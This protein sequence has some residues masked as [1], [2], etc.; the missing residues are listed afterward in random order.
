MNSIRNIV[1]SININNIDNWDISSKKLPKYVYHI[2]LHKENI[3]KIIDFPL[4]YISKILKDNCDIYES[5]LNK[6]L[7]KYSI[8]FINFLKENIFLKMIL[9][10]WKS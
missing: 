4:K 10:Y 6:T 8:L 5:L 9:S 1:F 2:I 3:S 7:E